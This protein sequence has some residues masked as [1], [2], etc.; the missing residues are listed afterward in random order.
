MISFPERV[1]GKITD[2]GKD[3]LDEKLKQ[4][5]EKYSRRSKIRLFILTIWSLTPAVLLSILAYLNV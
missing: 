5:F 2:W 1:I 3:A 4:K